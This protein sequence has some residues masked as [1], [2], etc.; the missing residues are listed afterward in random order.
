MWEC[1]LGVEDKKKMV[2]MNIII[3]QTIVVNP[4]EGGISRM[5]KIYYDFLS[6]RGYNVSFLSID[7]GNRKMLPHQYMVKGVTWEEKRLSFHSIVK[8]LSTDV[9]IYQNGISPYYNYILRWSKECNV[10]IVDVIHNT[11]RG[12]YGI[13]GHPTLSKIKPRIVNKAI[14]KLLN[15][16]FIIKYRTKYQEQFKLSDR[17]VLL[18]DKFKDEITYF[19]G[20]HDF[21][22]FTAI[23]N[24]LS[25]KEPESLNGNKSNIVLHVALFNEQKRQD[26]LLDVWKYV[27]DKRPEWTLKIVGNGKMRKK[28][29]AKAMKLSLKR[30]YFL[31]FQSPQPYYDEAAIFCL[32]SAFESFGLVLV[33][34]MAYGCVPMAFN[35]FETV[36]DIINDEVNGL[37]V[38]PFDTKEYAKKLISLMDDI[39][40][41]K[42]M[43]KRAVEKSRTFHME[44][45]MPQWVALIEELG[46]KGEK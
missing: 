23:L 9:L 4:D 39:E 27:E 15:F 14:D 19:T 28:L 20:W 34:S 44:K 16:F 5:S 17:V 13:G 3:F 32:T 31:G 33:E 11:L 35:S 12:M 26:L 1:F 43:S 41:R 36:T 24:P 46:K 21:S 25:I 2:S 18:S 7:I 30:A 8:G 22:K 6:K 42:K 38:R 40:K 45:I 37:L 10:K 29:L